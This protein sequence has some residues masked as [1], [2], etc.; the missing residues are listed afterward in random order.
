MTDLRVVTGTQ[1]ILLLMGAKGKLLQCAHPL[2]SGA[3]KEQQD[4]K[5]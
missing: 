3:R 4:A 2:V 5:R 1:N